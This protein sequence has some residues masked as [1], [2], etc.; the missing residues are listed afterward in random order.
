[1]AETDPNRANENIDELTWV[2]QKALDPATS[3][4]EKEKLLDRRE[5]ILDK[6]MERD[7]KNEAHDKR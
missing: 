1:M 5:E 4:D 6:M 2:T 7:Q 3:E